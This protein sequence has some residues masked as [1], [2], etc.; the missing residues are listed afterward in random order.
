MLIVTFS[1]LAKK[2]K[3]GQSCIVQQ[4]HN[5]LKLNPY[6]K[7]NRKGV[8]GKYNNFE[9]E[10]QLGEEPIMD[11][12]QIYNNV[13]TVHSGPV[14]PPWNAKNFKTEFEIQYEV[15]DTPNPASESGNYMDIKANKIPVSPYQISKQTETS[16][17]KIYKDNVSINSNNP[18]NEPGIYEEAW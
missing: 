9:K 3:R 16:L 10:C 5:S 6:I 8:E 18:G 12:Q 17:V 13:E 2:I 14:P 1:L 4:G 11:G 7:T 15:L